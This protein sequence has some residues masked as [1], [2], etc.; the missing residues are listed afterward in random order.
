MAHSYK[1]T[2]I[3]TDLEDWFL[4]HPIIYNKFIVL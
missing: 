2:V 3:K 1:I 4:Y